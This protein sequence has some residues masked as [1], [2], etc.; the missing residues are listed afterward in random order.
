MQSF[1]TRILA[2]ALAALGA[3]TAFAEE[4]VPEQGAIQLMLLRQ[5]SVQDDLKLSSDE[6]QK[7]R[8]FSRAQWNR[9]KALASAPDPERKAKFGEMAAENHAFIN[10]TLT[11]PQ[12]QRLREIAYQVA[13]LLYITQPDIAKELNLTDDQKRQ[14]AERQQDARKDL[15]DLMHSEK[16]DDAL[17]TYKER[18][19]AVRA[20]AGRIL[21]DEQRD[22]WKHMKGEPFK[23]EFDYGGEMVPAAPKQ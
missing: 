17:K 19:E 15:V 22:K 13:G 10:K 16:L 2:L 8:G 21:T 9:A 23:G 7:I 5:K 6:V 14:L 1:S 12:Q 3:R 18:R 20:Q 4:L 11:Q